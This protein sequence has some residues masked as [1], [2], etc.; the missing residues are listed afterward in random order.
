LTS[1]YLLEWRHAGTCPH[2]DSGD[3][4]RNKVFFFAGSP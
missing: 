4:L 1:F 2:L 3:V